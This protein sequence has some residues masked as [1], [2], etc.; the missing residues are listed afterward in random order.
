MLASLVKGAGLVLGA[1][2]A[3]SALA[4]PTPG[5]ASPWNGPWGGGF[6]APEPYRP[7][8][9][10]Y[11]ASGYG[12]DYGSVVQGLETSPPFIPGQG[13]LGPGVQILPGGG[14]IVVPGGAA[15]GRRG[16]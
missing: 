7:W 12:F 6:M 4:G 3:G 2:V 11:I 9:S 16:H 10:P 13:T 1:L 14:Y 8:D 15:P 5:V